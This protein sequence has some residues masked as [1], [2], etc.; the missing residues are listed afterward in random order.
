MH[1]IS[2]LTTFLQKCEQIAGR[3]Q[4]RAHTHLCDGVL[5][6]AH[7]ISSGKVFILRSLLESQKAD[8]RRK[9]RYVHEEE[10]ED[11]EE[12]EGDEVEEEGDEE[13]EEGDDEEEGK[14]LIFAP[15]APIFINESATLRVP[16]GTSGDA[17]LRATCSSTAR[18]GRGGR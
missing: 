4:A 16:C 12:E 18:G 11:E 5:T 9:Q 6:K 15:A 7:E 13:E 10:E 2:A 1:Q 3:A 8:A 17:C 14:S